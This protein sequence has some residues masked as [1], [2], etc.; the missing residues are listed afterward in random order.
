MCRHLNPQTFTPFTSGLGVCT[1]DSHLACHDQATSNFLVY[2]PA[3]KKLTLQAE[4][5]RDPLLRGDFLEGSNSHA[6]LCSKIFLA[7]PEV[8]DKPLWVGKPVSMLI[9]EMGGSS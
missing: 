4:H 1:N 2:Y 8:S 9:Q 3:P 5:W 7:W 6:V